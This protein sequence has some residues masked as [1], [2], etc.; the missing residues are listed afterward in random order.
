[1]T[2]AASRTGQYTSAWIGADRTGFG[3]VI[4]PTEIGDGIRYATEFWGTDPAAATGYGTLK[5]IKHPTW[6]IDKQRAIAGLGE[7]PGKCNLQV[8]LN[9]RN[10]RDLRQLL[11]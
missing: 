6:R 3:D 1:M 4:R 11:A 5:Q 2:L 8:Q 9:G 10:L 7:I